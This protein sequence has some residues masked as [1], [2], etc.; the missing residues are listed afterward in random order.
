MQIICINL[1]TLALM[2]SIAILWEEGQNRNLISLGKQRRVFRPLDSAIY[3]SLG[4]YSTP[5]HREGNL[6]RPKW[7]NELT[8]GF[9]LL[10]EHKTPPCCIDFSWRVMNKHLFTPDKVLTTYQSNDVTEVQFGGPVSSLDLLT[11]N[12]YRRMG[13]YETAKSPQSLVLL[14]ITTLWKLYH[15]DQFSI[16]LPLPMYSVYTY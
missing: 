10:I 4:C 2:L 14:W 13:H 7:C 1:H 8:N 12:E 5:K 11:E 9:Y 3:R 15:G 6:Q 16:N